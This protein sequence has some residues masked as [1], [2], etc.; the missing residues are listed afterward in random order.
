MRC[1]IIVIHVPALM[2][3]EYFSPLC[4]FWSLCVFFVSVNGACCFPMGAWPLMIGKSEEACKLVDVSQ[5][6]GDR[7]KKERRNEQVVKKRTEELEKQKV[8]EEANAAA[9][10]SRRSWTQARQLMKDVHRSRGYFPVSKCNSMDVDQGKGKSRGKK[11]RFRTGKGKHRGKS[12]GKSKGRRPRPCL[13]CQAP[14]WARD[15]PS[16]H[17]GKGKRTVSSGKGYKNSSPFRQAYLEGDRRD[18]ITGAGAFAV[19]FPSLQNFASFDLQG[20]FIL[21]SG[22]VLIFCKNFKRFK[23]MLDFS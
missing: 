18:W 1:A 5:R 15:S 9:D 8:K 21:D 13:L 19:W 14:H 2:N 17:G 10:M 20:K 3:N 4:V 23:Q 11:G 16:H 7:K 6:E 22:E 12:K